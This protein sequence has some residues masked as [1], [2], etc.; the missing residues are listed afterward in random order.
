MKRFHVDVHVDD[1]VKSIGFYSKLFAAEP[2]RVEVDCAKWML[3]DPSKGD[4]P[5]DQM[6]E[7]FR[8]TVHLIKRQLELLINLPS[9]KL[10]K[11]LLQPTARELAKE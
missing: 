11:A 1:F 7:A 9:G 8:K 2:A 6:L 4:A 3:D 5:D 10:D